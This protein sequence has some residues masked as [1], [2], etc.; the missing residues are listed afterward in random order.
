MRAPSGIRKRAA[1]LRRALFE[2]FGSPRYSRPGV[3]DLDHKLSRY[4]NFRNGFFIE[5]G[6]NDGFSQ[7][8]TY[9]LERFLGWSGI[10]VEGIPELAEQCRRLRTRSE[11]HNCALVSSGF[12]AAEISMRYANLMS[13]VD[14]SLKTPSAQDGHVQHGL[15]LQGLQSSY[16]LSVPARTLTSILD[17]STVPPR[18]DFLSLDVEGYELEALRG[19]DL[20]RYRPRFILA[21]IRFSADVTDYLSS[22]YEP[23]DAITP[24]DVLYGLRDQ[25]GLDDFRRFA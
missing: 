23:L 14:G 11:V 6:A 13:V 18:I 25:R 9:F 15:A 8:N 17:D 24:D 12:A 5:A 21:E 20:S 2:F 7:S 4:L 1:R 19:L 3:Y 16:E 22:C 10:L